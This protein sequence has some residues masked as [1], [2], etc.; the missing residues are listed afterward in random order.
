MQEV[1]AFFSNQSESLGNY[2]SF[3]ISVPADN[4]KLSYGDFDFTFQNNYT[5][6]YVIEDNSALYPSR[7]V[8]TYEFDEDHFNF[9]LNVGSTTDSNKAY[10]ID[11]SD[12]TSWTLTSSSGIL[13]FTI[14]GNFTGAVDATNNWEAFNRT[15][16][17]G[18]INFLRCQINESS[19]S[20]SIRLKNYTSSTW[21]TVVSNVNL[22]TNLG[23]HDLDE[24][25]INENLHYIDLNDQCH[26]EFIF[27][28]N[29]S[30]EFELELYETSLQSVMG[31]E[32]DISNTEYVALEFDLRG[33]STQV[34]GFHAWIRTLNQTAAVGET[35]NISLYKADGTMART[36]SNLRSELIKP[37]YSLLIDNII[38][39]YLADNLSYFQF[40]LDNTSDLSYYN[41]FIVIKSDAP[42]GVYSL[43]SIPYPDYGDPTGATEH[44][45]KKTINDGAS[46]TNAKT[47]IGVYDS[48]QL[49]ASSFKLNITR[50]YM[51]SDFDNSLTIQNIALN[52]DE[53][54]DF[55]PFNGN[56]DLYG[57]GWEKEWGKGTWDNDFSTA[58]PGDLNNDFQVILTWYQNIT[59]GFEFNV[60]YSVEAYKIESAASTY[61]VKYE[62]TPEWN[63]SYSFNPNLLYWN[64]SE[65]W[66]IYPNT[67]TPQNLYN[68]SM[69]DPTASDFF[70]NSQVQSFPESSNYNIYNAS[71]LH[72]TGLNTGIFN[73]NL[74]SFN[75]VN[76]MH[77]YINFNG[78]LWETRG[79]MYGD[80]ISLSL[81]LQNTLGLAPT[82]G[83]ANA[84]LFQDGSEYGALY[85]TSGIAS[86]I[87]NILYYDFSNQTI[88]DVTTSDKL[89]STYYLGYFWTNGTEIGCK[90]MRIYLE[91]FDA[92]IDDCTYL[93]SLDVNSLTGTTT[94]SA[95]D[96][97]SLLIASVNETTGISRPGYF[98]ISNL[99]V[100][101]D[102]TYDI[103]SSPFDLSVSL[104]T[105]EQSENI[106]NPEETVNFKFQVKNLDD[107]FSFNVKIKVQLI[108]YSNNEWIINETTSNPIL[109]KPIGENG[110]TREFAIDLMIPTLDTNT[111]IWEG[112]NSPIRM[113]GAR[114]V[115]TIYIE[116][117]KKYYN[118][119]SYSS[120][121]YSLIVSQKED[122][123]E[124][125][126][127]DLKT[128][129]NFGEGG[130]SQYFEREVCL[131]NQSGL[132]ST[133]VIN[134]YTSSYTSSYNQTVRRFSLKLNSCFP[135]SCMKS[136]AS[137]TSRVF[138][139][140]SAT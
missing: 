25:V 66:Y 84:T 120:S 130:F 10:L 95:Y 112:I 93:P 58:I 54:I 37:N 101:E 8:Q 23:I 27:E 7:H 15:N 75:C 78:N 17:L 22:S 79:F 100:N 21:N 3:N 80:N 125:H 105:F 16:I 1:R 129:E 45:L 36:A 131:Y 118:V 73:L 65:F 87:D 2:G 91:S 38:V 9:T 113:G 6:D 127:L 35:L 56:I 50:G 47:M 26:V 53:N 86:S 63:L 30:G 12:G 43:V 44:Q 89:G 121:D 109:L 98:P 117:D 62:D 116:Y 39:P 92:T 19:A 31:F 11:S 137:L 13:N 107:V 132:N 48:R 46:W 110:S 61:K 90:K 34:N 60:S 136:S 32:L 114:T 42:I 68:V 18:I 103:P 104:L 51:P 119:G 111:K 52:D 83:Y 55:S 20:F 96:Y 28:K 69:Q 64:F 70:S 124:G 97:Y 49:D 123:F 94:D 76:D 102:Y 106:L 71:S 85:S 14:E 128:R 81:D 72:I 108:S 67:M 140:R 88:L 24:I 40:N 126:I 41:Y 74:T 82:G 4:M 138:I 33:A 5:T 99:S 29:T 59:K 134:T 77:S 115:S 122:E 57:I 133:F 135:C 139:N